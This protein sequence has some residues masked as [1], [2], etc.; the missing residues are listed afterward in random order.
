MKVIINLQK[1]FN[2]ILTTNP[3]LA[4]F[5]APCDYSEE[6]REGWLSVSYFNTIKL[7]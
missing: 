7:S 3:K 2:S 5:V 4:S 1:H 6:G